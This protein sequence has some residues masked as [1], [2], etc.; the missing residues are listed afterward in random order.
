MSHSYDLLV[1]HQL[2]DELRQYYRNFDI[3]RLLLDLIGQFLYLQ[4]IYVI[5]GNC[6]LLVVKR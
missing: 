4:S 5:K 6:E 2:N 1:R 3:L